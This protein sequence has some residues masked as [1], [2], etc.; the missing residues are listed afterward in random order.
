MQ[1][2]FVSL[3]GLAHSWD[4]KTSISDAGEYTASEIQ[5]GL[6]TFLQF[7]IVI[8]VA[9]AQKKFFKN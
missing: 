7:F 5:A 3:S 8:F 2:A 1:K 9:H 4:W 6:S